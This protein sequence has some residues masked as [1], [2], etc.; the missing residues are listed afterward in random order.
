MINYEIYSN[1]QYNPNKWNISVDVL[2][3]HNKDDAYEYALIDISLN[4]RKCLGI[5]VNQR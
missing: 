2:F 5:V 4:E 1:V 3:G